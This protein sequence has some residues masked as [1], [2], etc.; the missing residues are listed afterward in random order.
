LLSI[1]CSLSFGWS[2]TRRVRGA[3]VWSLPTKGAHCP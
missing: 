3:W 2:F 1:G